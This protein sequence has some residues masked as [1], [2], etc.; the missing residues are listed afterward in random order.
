MKFILAVMI[1]T[2]F[3]GAA[4]AS[5]AQAAIDAAPFPPP[6]A[7]GGY[8]TS[9][10]VTP[11]SATKTDGYGSPK[12]GYS[13][14]AMTGYGGAIVLVPAA[15]NDTGGGRLVDIDPLQAPD[16]VKGAR[17]APAVTMTDAQGSVWVFDATLNGWRNRRTAAVRFSMPPVSP[18]P[19]AGQPPWLTQPDRPN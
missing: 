1:A 15:A 2:A 12:T 17:R 19:A 13:V 7:V 18:Q 3:L 11:Y 16:S 9:K 8:A 5:S 10:N 4:R 14:N 6:Q